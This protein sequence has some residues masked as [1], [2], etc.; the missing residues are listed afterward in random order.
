MAN[1][2]EWEHATSFMNLASALIM[3]IEFDTVRIV[4]A[5]CPFCP[6]MIDHNY[7]HTKLT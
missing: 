6:S 7:T 3:T 2:I 1:D 5:I 4:Y